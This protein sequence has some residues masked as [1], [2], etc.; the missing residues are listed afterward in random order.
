MANLTQTVKLQALP[1]KRWALRLWQERRVYYLSLPASLL[2]GL[3]VVVPVLFMLRMSLYTRVYPSIYNPGTWTLS[4]YGRFFTNSY[5]H[6]LLL[7]TVRIAGIV[8][9]GSLVLGYPVAYFLV[10]TQSR[11]R[12][13][14]FGLVIAKFM[15][16]IVVIAYGWLVLMGNAGPINWLLLNL[17]LIDEPIRMALRPLGGLIAMSAGYAPFQILTIMGSIGGIDRDVEDASATLGANKIQTFFRVTLP[18][19]LPGMMGGSIIVALLAMTA[20][21]TPKMV[22][23]SSMLTL[24]VEVYANMLVYLNWPMAGALALV[25]SVSTVTIFLFIRRGLRPR[26]LEAERGGQ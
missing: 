5:Y 3:L 11:W 14:L 16:S 10:R 23:G 1:G 20:F 22:G 9:L 7:E 8:T 2:A 26:Y 12:P 18:L 4:N 19:S 25:M 17:G 24:G 21:A 15:I 13:I 6:D